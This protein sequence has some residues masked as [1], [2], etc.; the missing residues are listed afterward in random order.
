MISGGD[1][2][3]RDINSNDSV[4]EADVTYGVRYFKGLGPAPQCCP[5]NCSTIVTTYYVY[6]GG[7]VIAEYNG[8]KTLEWNYINGLG[9][10]LARTKVVAGDTTQG[11][12]PQR[13]PGQH[14]GDNQR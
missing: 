6:S 11:D 1:Y 3:S 8:S 10:R 13:P 5:W 2:S 7:S 4:I 9:Q 14:A 12:L